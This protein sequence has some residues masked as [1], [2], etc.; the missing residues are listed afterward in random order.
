MFDRFVYSFKNIYN[1]YYNTFNSK[2]EDILRKKVTKISKP[3]EYNDIKNVIS[4]FDNE[5]EYDRYCCYCLN[6]KLNDIFVKLKCDHDMH[7]LCFEKFILQNNVCPF[8]KEKIKNE[9]VS[10]DINNLN[11][12]YNIEEMYYK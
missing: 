3:N 1:I 10:D 4:A 9:N 2:I 7:Y 6:P 11:F 5:N 12:K 8:C